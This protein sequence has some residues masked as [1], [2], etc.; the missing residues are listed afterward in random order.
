MNTGLYD[1][2]RLAPEDGLASRPFGY[3]YLET[4]GLDKIEARLDMLRHRRDRDATIGK[5]QK[6]QQLIPQVDVN[7]PAVAEERER[8]VGGFLA[9]GLCWLALF[10]QGIET[11]HGVGEVEPDRESGPR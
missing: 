1:G 3:R 10:P 9:D 8:T 7:R 4:E 6:D 11:R 2:D 5:R